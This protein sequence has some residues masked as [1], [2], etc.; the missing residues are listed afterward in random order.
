MKPP[1]I[2][3][4]LIALPLLGRDP[5]TKRIAHNDPSKY[6]TAKAVHDGA[7]QLDYME[8]FDAA[9]LDV[10]LLFVH[11]GVIHPNSGIGHHF[12][13]QMEEMFV[14]LDNEAQFTIDG[15]TSRLEGPAGSPCRIGHSHGIYNPTE[16]PNRVDEHR[17]RYREG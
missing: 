5:L 11:R 3:A 17:G 4:L 16:P 8:M 14:I 7:G 10:N 15:R 13:N 2:Y 12:H 9:A 1:L 6:E